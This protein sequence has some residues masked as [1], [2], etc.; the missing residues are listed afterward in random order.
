MGPRKIVRKKQNITQRIY[1]SNFWD[2]KVK[3]VR[4]KFV[5]SLTVLKITSSKNYDFCA[6]NRS[7]VP[8]KVDAFASPGRSLVKIWPKYIWDSEP[9]NRSTT[10]GVH[11]SLTTCARSITWRS[12]MKF[13]I[14]ESS[15]LYMWQ[16]KS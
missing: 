16:N 6:S 13:L 14:W 4:L 5:L 7:Q 15:D 9:Q 1:K 12:N 3:I 11:T 2:L 8:T 10:W